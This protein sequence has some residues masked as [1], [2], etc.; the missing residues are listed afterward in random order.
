MVVHAICGTS[1][2]EVHGK[3]VICI[4]WINKRKVTE[5]QSKAY[6]GLEKQAKKL[7]WLSNK[8]FSPIDVGKSV[9]VPIPSVDRGKGDSKNI[10]GVVLEKTEDNLYKIGTKSGTIDKLC[11]CNQIQ[12]CKQSFLTIEEVKDDPISVRS[13]NKTE[14]LFNGQGFIKCECNKKSLNN[15]CL[16]QKVRFYVILNVTIVHHVATNRNFFLSCTTKYLQF[17][18]KNFEYIRYC[19]CFI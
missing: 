11:T 5:Q 4:I 9:K 15:R 14:S 19:F 10:I 16:C 8:K 3:S 6:A 18:K 1:S 17:Q 2:T 7:T 13:I 12:S